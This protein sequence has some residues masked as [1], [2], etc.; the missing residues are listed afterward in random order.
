[1]PRLFSS[2]ARDEMRIA[3]ESVQLGN[4][5]R[6]LLLF[7]EGQSRCQLRAILAFPTLNLREFTRKLPVAVIQVGVDSR[8]LSFQAKAAFALWSR[9]N[10]IISY[11]FAVHVH[12]LTSG[13]VWTIGIAEQICIRLA[14]G[15]NCLLLRR[16]VLV[17]L[18]LVRLTLCREFFD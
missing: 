1:M 14:L 9:R 3:G 16:L 10:P 15:G 6:C 12:I 4:H 13:Y 18:V 2:W 7:S 17:R 5:Q 11:K 8:L